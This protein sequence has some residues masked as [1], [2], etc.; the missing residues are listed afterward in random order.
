MP[1]PHSSSKRQAAFFAFCM[2]SSFYAAPGAQAASTPADRYLYRWSFEAGGLSESSRMTSFG[3]ELTIAGGEPGQ[4]PVFQ[5]SGGG[6]SESSP[7]VLNASRNVY[8]SSLGAQVN[9]YGSPLQTGKTSGRFT[10]TMWVKAALPVDQQ[11]E[12]RLLNIGAADN[13]QGKQSVFI[14]IDQN[15]LGF[16]VNGSAYYRLDIAEPPVKVGE[17][18]F[19]VFCYDG[20]A[21]NPHYCPDMFDKFQ[22][23]RNGAVLAGGVNQTTRLV[24]DSALNT[25]APTYSVSPGPAVFNGLL[26][27]VGSSNTR[28]VRSFVGWIDDVRIYDEVLT[29]SQIEQVRLQALGK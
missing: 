24:C 2:L 20:A 4:V 14:C 15:S 26:V 27:A 1:R 9:S 17:W 5:H 3:G 23:S 16:T 19:L 22:S 10:I 11:P 13:E 28:F 8:G 6:V 18:S 12:A 25:G 21:N 29:L 7:D